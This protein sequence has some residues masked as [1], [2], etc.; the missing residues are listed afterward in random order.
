M[1]RP[2]L[3]RELERLVPSA[4]LR[5]YYLPLGDERFAAAIARFRETEKL[6]ERIGRVAAVNREAKTIAVQEQVRL[7]AHP[8]E[9]VGTK[10][11]AMMPWIAKNKLVDKARN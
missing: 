11:R 10:L 3:E 2:E 7:D 9:E 1:T 6:I 8:I 5:A 4:R